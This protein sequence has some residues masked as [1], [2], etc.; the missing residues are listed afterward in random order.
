MQN[1]KIKIAQAIHKQIPSLN[2]TEIALL[3][4][5]PKK[6]EHGHIAFPV[7]NMAKTLKKAPPVIAQEITKNLEP[8][9]FVESIIPL[10]GYINFV[11]KDEYLQKLIFDGQ[12]LEKGPAQNKIV[13]IDY[14]SPNVAKQMSIGHLRATV[15]GQAIRNLA[16]SQGYKVIGLNYLGDWGVQ[17]GKLAWAYKTW[18]SEYPFKEEPFESLNKLYVRFHD[19]AEKDAEIEKK[20]AATFKKLEE[21]DP[22]IVN[23]WK[24]FLDISIREYKRIYDLLGIKFDLYQGESFHNSHLEPTVELLKNAGLLKESDGAQVVFLDNDRPPCIIKKSDGTSLYA[25]RDIASA[26]YRRNE[27][28]GDQL[29]Y[30]VGSEQSLHFQQIFE[31]LK[32]LGYTWANNCHHISFGLYRFKDIGKMSTRKGNVIF[33]TDI[34]SRAIEIAT[35]IIEEKNPDLK[36][37]EQ[38]AKQ[39][40]IGAIIFNDLIGDRVKN[41]DFDWNRVLDFEGDSGPYVQYCIVRCKSIL[42]KAPTKNGDILP[43]SSDEERSLVRQLFL[44]PDILKTSYHHFKPNF[45][46]QYLLETCRAFN[47]FYAKHKVLTGDERLLPARL[48]LIES[49]QRTLIDGL[50]ILGI[51]SPDEM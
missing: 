43:L 27:L 1:F 22:E 41:V 18:G 3:L 24:M 32:K 25:T 19:E 49:T 51:E 42:K 48:K 21:H 15:I 50:R 20:G 44:Y 13:V 5:S 17:F 4:E 35:Q 14:S 39:V 16:E 8:L 34:L 45:L 23:L 26:I 9:N 33:M 12:T 11:I 28:K 6:L 37:K 7:F 29:L 10:G 46:A 47:H 31:V 30:V 38:V 40:G 36:N 2:Q